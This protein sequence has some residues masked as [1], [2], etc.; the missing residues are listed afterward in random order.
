MSAPLPAWKLSWIKAAQNRDPFEFVTGVLGVPAYDAARPGET[1]ERWQQEQLEALRNGK[2]RL[3]IRSGHGVG[4]TTFFAWLTLYALLCLGPDTKVPIA[5][6]SQ[7]QLRDTL[8]PEISKWHSR[9]PAALAAQIEVQLER[10]Q[11]VCAPQ[12]AFAVFRTASKDNPQALAGFHAKNVVFLIDEASAVAE[13]AFEVAAGALSSEGAIAVLA[14]NPTKSNGFFFETHHSMSHRWHAVRVSSEDVPRARGHIEDIIAAYGKNSN[15]YRVRVLGEFPTHDDQAVI[16]LELIEAAQ[17]R[18][19]QISDVFPVWGVDVARFGDDSSAL[20]KRQGNSAKYDDGR[21]PFLEWHGLDGAQVAGRIQ[22][23]YR[24]T[25]LPHR[26]KEIAIDVIGVGASVYDILRL[27]G[28]ECRDAVR[29]VNVSERPATSE[30]DHRLRDELWFRCFQWHHSRD[31]HLPARGSLYSERGN[32]LLAKLVSELSTPTYD[33]NHL[34]KRVVESKKA[35]KA[36]NVPSP[37]IADAWNNT[38]ACGIHP[39]S[40]PHRRAEREPAP[41]WRAA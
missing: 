27:D 13:V 9:L 30:E 12:D 38:F 6:G 7:S 33:F 1:M 29:G 23:E 17:G 41:S 4:K 26:P 36:R 35:L 19:I 14:G 15:K 34:G 31:C 24:E 3:S 8:Q 16:P 25:A 22:A 37:N 28:S 5:A 32:M 2:Q 40:N 18:Q 21:E 39:R 20:A 11:M 10:I